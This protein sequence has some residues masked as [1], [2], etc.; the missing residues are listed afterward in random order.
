MLFKYLLAPIALAAS[1]VCYPPPGYSNGSPSVQPDYGVDFNTPTDKFRQVREPIASSC[2]R[3]AVQDVTSKL[4]GLYQPVRT[5][6]VKFHSAVKVDTKIAI[7]N[8]Q[9]LISFFA[10][11]QGIVDTL[12][13]YPQV[14]SSSQ[15]TLLEFNTQFDSILQDFS[16]AGVNIRQVFSQRTS[17]K[18][19]SWQ[20]L[21]F[22]FPQKFG[23]YENH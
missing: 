6:S 8:T 1:V 14:V 12:V 11:F 17:V 10:G 23:L 19:E 3:Q 15:E 4:D 2:K 22:T 18:F 5:L 7:K 16:G 21:G 9:S 13:K 20:K